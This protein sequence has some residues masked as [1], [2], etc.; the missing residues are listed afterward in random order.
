MKSA[1]KRV[2]NL[3]NNLAKIGLSKASF[4]PFSKMFRFLEA[5]KIPY[6]Y[7]DFYETITILSTKGRVLLTV[8]HYRD[9]IGYDY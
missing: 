2:Q 4:C 6:S 5:N 3:I 8:T 7:D 1:S 9:L